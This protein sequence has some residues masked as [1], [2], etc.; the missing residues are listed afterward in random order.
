MG[1][2]LVKVILYCMLFSVSLL[3]FDSLTSVFAVL[4]AVFA[5]HFLPSATSGAGLPKFNL[6]EKL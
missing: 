4:P 5:L 3:I 2:V 6:K 1:S